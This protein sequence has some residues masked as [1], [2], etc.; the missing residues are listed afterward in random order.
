VSRKFQLALAVG[1]ACVAAAALA[2]PA[3]AAPPPSAP[4]ALAAAS[5][6]AASF[7]A[8]KPAVLKAS[9]D[10]QFVQQ[11]VVSSAGLQYVSYERTFHGMPV[12]GGDFVVVTD[13]SGAVQDLSVAQDRAIGSLS[14]IP[15]ISAAKA[16]SVARKQ[17]DRVDTAATPVLSVY[18]LGWCGTR[19]W[20]AFPARSSRASRSTSTR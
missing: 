20:S 15:K 7:V 4:D 18:A 3:G 13:K 11:G 19:W 1:T 17:M 14:T 16:M 9:A 12:I 2:V 10:E 6:S 5:Q 8:A